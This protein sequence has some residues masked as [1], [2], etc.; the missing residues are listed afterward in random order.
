MLCKAVSF[1]LY[2][3]R[4]NPLCFQYRHDYCLLN[5]CKSGRAYVNEVLIGSLIFHSVPEGIHA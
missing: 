4:D 2:L 1:W 5:Q 3:W